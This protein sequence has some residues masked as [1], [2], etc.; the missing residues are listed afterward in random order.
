MKKILTLLM[1]LMLANAPAQGEVASTHFRLWNDCRPIKTGASFRSSLSP[2]KTDDASMGTQ[3]EH[4]V[5]T[6]LSESGM[7]D[8]TGEETLLISIWLFH[9]G[10]HIEVEYYKKVYGPVAKAWGQAATYEI[11]H[12][13]DLSYYDLGGGTTYESLIMNPLR[14]KVVRFIEDWHQANKDAC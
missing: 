5:K 1:A 13:D 9:Y 8:P 10:L 2:I 11:N 14:G 6:L 3:A 7:Y 12:T 4:L